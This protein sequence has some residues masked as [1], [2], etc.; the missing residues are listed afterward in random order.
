VCDSHEPQTVGLYFESS[1]ELVVAAL[2]VWKA[3]G[4]YLPVDPA[5][6][7]ERANFILSDAGAP[8][9]LAS[10]AH[11]PSLDSGPWK[12]IFIEDIRADDAALR[13]RLPEAQPD[14]LAYV[15]YTSGSTG[16]PKGV[17]ITHSNLR[18]LVEWHNREFSI[19]SPRINPQQ[20][21]ESSQQRHEEGDSGTEAPLREGIGQKRK[22]CWE[23]L[24][25]RSCCGPI[26]P[27]TRLFLR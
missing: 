8:I 14:D 19:T 7:A 10:R 6:P 16:Q 18:N 21:M 13:S 15:I 5:Y 17:E 22:L 27:E 24:S 25:T 20:G 4:A 2:G 23:Y 3:G 9:V 11:A 1:A 12:T 26:F